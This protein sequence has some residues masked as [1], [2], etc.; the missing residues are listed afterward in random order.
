MPTNLL[1]DRKIKVVK[2]E[3]KEFLLSDGRGL[4]LRVRPTGAK[5]WL[6]IYTFD[7]KRRKMGLGSFEGVTLASARLEADKARDCLAKQ[8]DPQLN[9]KLLIAEQTAQR[10]SLE[11]K[12]NRLKVSELFERWEKF[13]LKKRKDHGKEVRRSFEKDLIPMLGDTAAEDLSRT[14]VVNLLDKVVE[15]GAPVIARNMLG[16]IRQM[17]GF[18][19]VR[20][21]VEHDPT[22]RLKRDDF[23]KKVERDRILDE[24][25]IKSLPEKL[26]AARMTESS[27]AAIWIMLSTCCR[28][29]EITRAEWQHIDLHNK[30]WRIP[31]DNS[32]NAKA[33][34]VH[35]SDFAF[36][37]FL[38]LKKLSELSAWVMPA[39]WTNQHVC[40][41][42]LS[43]QVGDR[44]RGDKAPMKC[45]SLHTNALALDGGRWTPHDLRRTGAT[46][47]GM[48]GVR[49]DVIEKCLNHVEQNKVARIYQRQKLE[50]EQAEAWR[51]LSDRL[52][53]ILNLSTENVSILSARVA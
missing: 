20:G 41:K 28:V 40:V 26:K 19:I 34:T 44:Q 53:L 35:L 36:N 25:E 31:P 29:G 32:K 14:M 23:G 33:L 37:Q 10:K 11:A 6:F 38:E 21:L 27:I 13:E 17:Y 4:F 49:P 24:L 46:M 30:T 8:L 5:D 52:D 43:K 47:M 39:R 2:S 18:G 42:S 51:L 48:L 16:D 7:S 50:A 12:L 45:R 1:S 9:Q 22:N 15:R 3:D